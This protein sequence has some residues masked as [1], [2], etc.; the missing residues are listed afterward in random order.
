MLE[1]VFV[2][3][4]LLAVLAA[5]EEEDVDLLHL[6][7]GAAPELDKARVVV[8]PL[9]ALEQGEDVAPIAVDVHQVG[10][11]PADCER[12]PV[13]GHFECYVSQYGLAQP[14]LTSSAR[15]SSMAV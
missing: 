3:E 6:L 5:T 13:L 9:G 10:V 2:D 1:Q 8:A 15:R 12:F 14:R 4:R 7:G 11:E